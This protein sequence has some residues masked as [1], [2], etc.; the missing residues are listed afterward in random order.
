MKKCDFSLCRAERLGPAKYVLLEDWKT[1]FGVIPKGFRSDGVTTDG[2]RLL[3]SPGGSL[4]EA[5]VIHDWLYVNHTR[6]K[7][8]ADKAFYRT[9]LV[10]G[11][12]PIRAWLAYQLVRYKGKGNY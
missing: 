2:F 11:V 4:F 1:P 7:E 9:A 5:A 6:T 12:H 10:Y 8:Y 3:A